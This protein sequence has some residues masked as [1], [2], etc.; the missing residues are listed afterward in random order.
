MLP[1]RAELFCHVFQGIVGGFAFRR[2]GVY[3]VPERCVACLVRVQMCRSLATKSTA[4]NSR[5]GLR[6]TN[7]KKTHEYLMKQKPQSRTLDIS[8]FSN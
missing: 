2:S 6:C 5:C 8:H 3:P 1:S 4:L 7:A